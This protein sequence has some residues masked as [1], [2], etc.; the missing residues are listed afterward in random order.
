VKELAAAQR[1]LSV[2]LCES[3]FKWA[4]LLAQ[5]TYVIE[6]GETHEGAASGDRGE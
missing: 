2:L 6:R 5:K 3:E 1:D 4:R